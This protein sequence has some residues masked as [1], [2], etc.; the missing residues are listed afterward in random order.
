MNNKAD[1]AI[2]V[3]TYN[4]YDMAIEAMNSALMQKKIHFHVYVFDNCSKKRF[5]SVLKGIKYITYIRHKE[6]IGFA[7]N[8]YFALDY[9][10]K[11]GHKFIYL[12]GDDDRIAYQTAIY[13]L[14]TICKKYPRVGVVRGGF[15]KFYKSP[16]NINQIFLKR[17]FN[18]IIKKSDA[19]NSAVENNMT[20]YS[21]ILFRN[22]PISLS[23]NKKFD[24][25][26]P[27]LIPIFK[28]LKTYGFAYLSKITILARCEH[29]QLATQVY[30]ENISNN[31]GFNYALSTVGHTYPTLYY[32]H[33]L[34]NYKIFGSNKELIRQYYVNFLSKSG[35]FKKIAAYLIYMSPRNFLLI[36]KITVK[37]IYS[38]IAK[39]QIKKYSYIIWNYRKTISHL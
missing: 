21:G 8:F 20:F 14:V 32:L 17:N 34:I 24:L 2:I 5:D 9:V 11:R 12:L 23:N 3:L 1:I 36:M 37:Y 26:S 35:F 10:Q 18:S 29:I 28:I 31:D 22:I 25:T 15:A 39:Q 33:E 30:S 4:R 38:L 6:N 19:I 16:K 7:K 27:F 13:D